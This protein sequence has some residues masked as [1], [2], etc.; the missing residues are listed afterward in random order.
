MCYL[1]V[2]MRLFAFG[3]RRSAIRES[4]EIVQSEQVH[5]K[6]LDLELRQAIPQTYDQIDAIDRTLAALQNDYAK[7]C[8]NAALTRAQR[9]GGWVDELML[10]GPE[11]TS[12]S[13]RESL[14]SEEL[15][16]RLTYAELQNLSA[17]P[18]RRAQ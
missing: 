12:L 11:S 16:K 18:W 14:E 9:H 7:I 8:N 3:Q 15:L 4:Q 17:D 2:E 10:I 1:Q 13:A 5:L 6:E